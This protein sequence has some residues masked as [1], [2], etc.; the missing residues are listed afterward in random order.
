MIETKAW[1]V[2]F[3][4]E[5]HESGFLW[6]NVPSLTIG[7][8]PWDENGYK[9]R[10]EVRIFYTEKGLRLRF[11]SYEQKI[12]AECLNMNDPVYNDSCVE[13]FFNPDP[14]HG[15][16]YM[17]FEINP[18]GTLRLGFGPNRYSRTLI[19][20]VSPKIFNI[21]P[22]LSAETHKDYKGPFWIIEYTV[23][24]IFIEQY[25]GKLSFQTG[26]RMKGN[27][28]KC[29]DKTQFPHYGCWNRIDNPVPDFHRPEFF[30]DLVLG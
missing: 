18:I 27:F 16:K 28:Y 2:P 19:K 30:G 9:P 14:E 8:F 23:P 7:E 3:F 22:S 24:F 4:S 5:K 26:K 25:Y 21:K 6:E 13:F 20:N 17:N 12:R 1:N 29:G 11:K 15:A 10:T